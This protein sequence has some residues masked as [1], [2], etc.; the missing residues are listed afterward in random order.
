MAKSA[1]VEK[2]VRHGSLRLDVRK[3]ADGRFGFD[4]KPPGEMRIKVRLETAEKA[5]ERAGEIL[6]VA[7]GGKVERLAIDEGEYAEFL[8]WKAERTR[9]AKVADVVA[10]FVA[11]KTGKGRSVHHV[12]RLRRDLEAFSKAFPVMIG[13]LTRG[14]VE[15]WL[16]ARNVGP[17]RW[18]NLRE[19][20]VALHR[21]ARR[22]GLLGAALTG[23]ELI[24]RRRVESDVATYAPAELH[25]IL[26]VVPREWLPF[27]VLGAFCG[28]RPME[29]APDPKS[30]KPPLT[31]GNILWA[32]K[33]VDVPAKVSKTRRRRFVPLSEA[34]AAFL[35]DRRHEPASAR[36]CP[37]L[38]SP[39]DV[40]AKAAGVPWKP[41]A[42]RHSYASYRLALTQDMAALALEL[43]NSPAMIFTHY[44]D[45]KHEDEAREW[46]AIRPGKVPKAPIASPK[47]VRAKAVHRTQE[48]RTVHAQ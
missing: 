12:G 5:I 13:E 23:P 24:E 41:D 39:S 38:R 34:A 44:L 7:H 10:S 2:T 28:I 47:R 33:K 11:S 16:N 3:Y 4:Y 21:F 15:K 22:E 27:V 25:K 19:S 36:L 42:L 30:G 17:R 6:G 20:I 31:W 32:K 29:I 18:N 46:F 35:R 9:K 1:P 37:F 14:N 48:E 8:R 26:A 43:G 40:W 45:L